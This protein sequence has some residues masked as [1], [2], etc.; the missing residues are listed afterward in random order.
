MNDK[1]HQN[2]SAPKLK[3]TAVVFRSP[4]PSG[5]ESATEE[6]AR[7]DGGWLFTDPETK[8]RMWVPDANVVAVKFA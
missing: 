5:P 4:V 6:I 3:P 2:Q 1:M 8:V 7:Q